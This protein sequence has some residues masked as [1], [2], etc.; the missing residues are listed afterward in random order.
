M[1]KF[2]IL[3][4]TIANANLVKLLESINNLTPSEEYQIEHLLV[5]DGPEFQSNVYDMLDIIKSVNYISRIVM[6]LP[7]N[8][9]AD[10]Y[11]GHKIYASISQII[12]ADY[13][14]FL[15]EDNTVEPNHIC[16]YFN[17]LKSNK[18]DWCYCL[19]NIISPEG[20]FV[21][22]D[23]CESLGAIH[24]VFY[25]D[26]IHL[27][28]TSCYCI[29]KD[30]L[31]KTSYI[32]NRKGLN[33]GSDPDR[34]FCDKLL[35]EYKNFKCTYE[36]TLNYRTSSRN[37]SVKQDLFLLGND[38]IKHKYG[39]IP[40]ENKTDQ[41]YVISKS[42][43]EIDTIEVLKKMYMTKSISILGIDNTESIAFLNY[44]NKYKPS[45]RKIL[46]I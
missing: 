35:S 16:A 10:G 31:I 4:P 22:K 28:D 27:I 44:Y 7:F 46:K 14:I 33:D 17:I 13:I 42:Y 3:T 25:N 40:W 15:D 43:L 2:T 12:N 32:W 45:D 36:H 41:M 24:S 38:R 29:S 11:Q 1:I 39:I 23:M 30:I 20:N 18:L 6:C 8:T 9:G 37:N 21:C 5:I 34:V 26:N 19:R